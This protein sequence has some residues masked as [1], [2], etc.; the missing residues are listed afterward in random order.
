MEYTKLIKHLWRKNDI[1][2]R[3]YL[4][5]LKYVDKGI[6]LFEVKILFLALPFNS[7]LYYVQAE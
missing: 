6:S 4:Y 5:L 7:G 1:W 3:G 2:L